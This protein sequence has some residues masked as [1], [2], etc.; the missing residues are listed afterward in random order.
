MEKQVIEYAGVPVGISVPEGN[1]V[2]FI[3]VKFPVIDL[4][5]G[6]YSNVTELHRA[7]RTHMK[8]SDENAYGNLTGFGAAPPSA[9]SSGVSKA[10]S[11]A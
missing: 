3:A 11:A 4:D 2:K 9:I 8:K 6:I 10:F 5:G 7:I 1:R